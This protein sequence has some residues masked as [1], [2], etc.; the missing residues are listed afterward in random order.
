MTTLEEIE[1]E[2][3]ELPPEKQ[4][5]VLDFILF[6]RQRAKAAGLAAP[7]S[8]KEHPAFGSWRDRGIDAL[9]YQERLRAEW[10][11]E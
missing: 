2:A 5:E 3:S 8:L 9:D 11:R 6:L 4:S 10:E 1:R 7:R